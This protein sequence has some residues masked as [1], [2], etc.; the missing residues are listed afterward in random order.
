MNISILKIK[1]LLKT[2]AL[3]LLQAVV[4]SLFMLSLNA[5]TP[6]TVGGT[7][8]YSGGG[9]PSSATFIAYITSRSGEVLT[10]SSTGCGYGGGSYWIQCGNFSTSWTAGDVLHIDLSDGTGGSTSDEIVLTSNP[11]DQLNLVIYSP[12][13]SISPTSWN[14]GSIEV[15]DNSTQGF[16]VTNTGG[17]TLSVTSTSLT[18][19]DAGEF[20]I[21]SGGGSFS[22]APGA[23][24]TVN[25]QFSPS[26]AGVKSASLS[27]ASND[28]DENP[29]NVSLNGTGVTIPDISASPNPAN[30]GSVLVWSYS[31]NTIVISNNGTGDL[32]VSSTT[33]T[34]THSGEFNI[35]SGGGSFTLAP[36]T[37]RNI[38]VRFSPTST[39]SKNA[40][41]QISNND[42]NE[43]PYNITLNGSGAQPDINV[44]PGSMNYEDVEIT[45]SS[46]ETFIVSNTGGATLSVSSSSIT[47]TDA[48]DFSITGGGGSFT[49]SP[50][51]TRNVYVRFSPSST[52]AKSAILRFDNDDPDEDPKDIS[53]SGNGI[54]IPDISAS[55]NPVNY[56][57]IEAGSYSDNTVTVSNDGTGTLNVSSTAITGT[58]SAEFSIHSGGGSFSL[59]PG[60]TRNIIVRFSPSSAGTKNASL[61]IS[62]D[63]P[64]EDPY[65]VNLNG[66]GILPDINVDPG[67][68]NFGDVEVG[69]NSTETFV[70]SNNGGA[71]LSV[72]STTLVGGNSDEFNITGG[73]GSF[74]L[75]PGAT[76]NVDVQFSPSSEGSKSTTLRF[77]SN[78]PD[79]NPEDILLSGTGT[80]IPDI[81]V[82]P[83][84]KNYGDVLIGF[85]SAQIFTVTN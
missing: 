80:V 1:S 34:G 45:S 56:G 60:A 3:Y 39:G 4:L 61:R 17:G 77:I 44:S 28:P 67:S 9:S 5:G 69:D 37:T 27:I 73:G 42:P 6:H 16:S 50:G 23:N 75:S 30:Y 47:G 41:L 2:R 7:V 57:S 85:G 29:L 43:N 51:A 26:S 82:S 72:S 48:G 68:M 12:D 54:V 52:G 22:L 63:D 33:V 13:I 66:T 84:I 15:G 14:Y 76:R 70:V 11:A 81:S 24:R 8:T 31:D 35:Q 65:Y 64:D 55:P 46:T 38:V 25:V 10:E 18:G 36:G 59:S 19:T 71:S 79:E 58:H 62:S 20:S 78:D 74:T 40:S 83:D 21:T 32:V 49:L 53:L